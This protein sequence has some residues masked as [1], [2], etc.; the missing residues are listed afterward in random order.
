M[1]IIETEHTE[2]GTS[3]R[4]FIDKETKVMYLF[5][6]NGYGGGLTIMLNPDGS[7]KLYQG[8]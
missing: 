1:T 3:Y 6:K 7:P 8:E 2:D 5:M 4:I